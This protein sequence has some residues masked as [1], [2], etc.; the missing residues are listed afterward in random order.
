MVLRSVSPEEFLE[1]PEGCCVTGRSVSLFFA[2]GVAGC[3]LGGA[4][5][6]EDI[7]TALR[8]VGAIHRASSEP[9]VGVIDATDLTEAAPSTF[10]HYRAY[11]DAYAEE[12]RR[13]VPRAAIARPGS[14]LLGALAEGFFRLVPMPYEVRLFADV[15]TASKW[16]GAPHASSLV[17]RVRAIRSEDGI[18]ARL[19]Q[20]FRDRLRFVGIEDGAT[21]LGLSPRSLQRR[22]KAEGTT[23]RRELDRARVEAAQRSMRAEDASLTRIAYEVGCASP[24]HLTT[25]FQ[26]VVGISP[27]V[28]RRHERELASS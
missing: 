17:A 5:E 15:R 26:R 12:L 8:L 4:V 9:F 19:R 20:V 27:S 18:A 2:E 23:F 6:G 1:A 21:A 24:A 7:A 11:V 10:G 3:V 28:W 22:L 25:L 16:L 14:F 13:Y